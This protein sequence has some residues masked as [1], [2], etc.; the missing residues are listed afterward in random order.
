MK[1]RIIALPTNGSEY[2]K[3][4]W[5]N[6]HATAALLGL[7]IHTLKSYRSLYWQCG[8]HYE[9]INSRTVRY[10]K[11]LLLDWLATRSNPEL[12]QRA[13]EAY[14]ASLPSNQPKVRGRRSS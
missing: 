2:A 8:I 9:Y 7:S 14:L 5:L 4:P 3:G 6:K 11:E 1:Q 10:H 12:H 13:I